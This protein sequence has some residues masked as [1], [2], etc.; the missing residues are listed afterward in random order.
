MKIVKV[1]GS[2]G[3]RCIETFEIAKAAINESGVD[4]ILEKVSNYQEICKFGFITTP[5]LVV[6]GTIK[7][8]NRVPTKDEVIA[9]LD[10]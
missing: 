4:A 7:A 1:L 3:P 9:W 8:M 6:E 5:A 10:E 2:G